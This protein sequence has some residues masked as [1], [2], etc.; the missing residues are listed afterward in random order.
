[1]WNSSRLADFVRQQSLWLSA[2]ALVTAVFWAIGQRINPATV[3][4]YAILLSNLAAPPLNWVRRKVAG[5]ASPSNWV[6]FVGTLLVL[7]P[8]VYAIASSIV[9][10][11][12]PPS[13][14]SFEHLLRTGWK[15]PCLTLFVYGVG[16]FLY[17]QTKE[18]LERRNSE[19]ERSLEVSAAQLQMQEQ[20]LQR[21]REI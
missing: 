7:T 21:A 5:K 14:Q 19:L 8:I 13:P 1:M 10:W 18:R 2:A 4:L 17:A 16:S 11:I 6:I 3:I 20:D 9:I 15:F 12:A